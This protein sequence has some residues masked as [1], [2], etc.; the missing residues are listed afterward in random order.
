MAQVREAAMPPAPDPA[1]EASLSATAALWISPPTERVE[2]VLRGNALARY[3]PNIGAQQLIPA[4]DAI[5]TGQR[6]TLR[7]KR[8]L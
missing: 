3:V 7:D 1:P 8:N 6:Y 4:P 2:E 5:V